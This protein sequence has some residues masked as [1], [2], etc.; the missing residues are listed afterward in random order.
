MKMI[1]T[2]DGYGKGL[3]KAGEKDERV[4][5]LCADL[6]EST[7]SH[8]FAEKFPERFIEVGVAEQNM[9][10]VAS[11][12]AN[13][14]KIPFISSYATFSP[15]RN[16]EQ[17]RTNI[18]IN[19]VP[20]KIAGHH[21]GISV[22]PD[23]ATHQALEDIALMRVQPKMVVIV[24]CDAIEAEK[25]TV[26][27][28]FNGQPTYIRFGREKSPVCTT[29]ESPFEIGKA[30]CF[31]KPTE[32][33]KPDVA[34]IGCGMLLYNALV[35]AE[36]LSREG[37]ESC[38]INSHTIKPIDEKM[39]IHAAKEAGAVVSVEEHQ[40]NGGLGSAVAEVLSKNYSVPQEFVGVQD[41]FGESGNPDEL[42]EAFGMGVSSIKEAV[43]KVIL[44]KQ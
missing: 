4:V 25:A 40:V 5:V 14:G 32:G 21:A 11:G 26:A 28:A 24:P 37:L 3:L 7:R 17:I 41:R 2:R 36:E 42:V 29:E 6:T 34:I 20:V 16:N 44:R 23:G 12:M 27:A 19:N 31:W 8:W 9:A 33:K 1:P 10:L 13:Y 38:V 43:K 35:A 22:G 15:G 30:T 18:C 39:I